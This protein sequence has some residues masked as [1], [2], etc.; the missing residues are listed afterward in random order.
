[1]RADAVRRRLRER[2]S[3]RFPPI[4]EGGAF[5]ILPAIVAMAGLNR[6]VKRRMK[7]ERIGEVPAIDREAAVVEAIVVGEVPLVV[8]H[9][10]VE[11]L[12]GAVKAEGH[13]EVILGAGPRHGG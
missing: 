3:S 12:V 4:P 2:N 9:P 1:M 7:H 6:S 10:V 13:A 11:R 5:V 8:R